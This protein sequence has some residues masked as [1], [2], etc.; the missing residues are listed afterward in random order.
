MVLKINNKFVVVQG[1][2][3]DDVLNISR[4]IN[5]VD[6]KYKDHMSAMSYNLYDVPKTFKNNYLKIFSLCIFTEFLF[7][8]RLKA[9]N[10]T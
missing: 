3:K 7:F 2:F 9:L 8:L 4:N 5:F 1:I 6:K 10:I